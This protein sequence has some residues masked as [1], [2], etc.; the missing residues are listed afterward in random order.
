MVVTLVITMTNNN[1]QRI[2]NCSKQTQ[3]K[4]NFTRRSTP[5]RRSES[6]DGSE[7]GQSQSDVEGKSFK[8]YNRSL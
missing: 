6:K 1:R 4:L 3:I 2:M 7:G 5:V 8:I